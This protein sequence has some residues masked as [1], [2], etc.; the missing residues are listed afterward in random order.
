M[1]GSTLPLTSSPGMNQHKSSASQGVRAGPLRPSCRYA[2]RGCL[3]VGHRPSSVGNAHSLVA[4]KG[5]QFAGV[6]ESTGPVVMS[7]VRP[8]RYL[9]RP[10]APRG[11]PSSDVLGPYAWL[12]EGGEFARRSR[13]GKESLAVV[14]P[15][16]VLQAVQP[17]CRHRCRDARTSSDLGWLR[18]RR[19]NLV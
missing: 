5:E 14:Q 3:D 16:E 17:S 1:R 13:S 8:I 11:D 9:S 4:C 10:G 7:P 6:A 12:R 18:P 2:H 15:G 19:R